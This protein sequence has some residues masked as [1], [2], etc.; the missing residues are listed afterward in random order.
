MLNEPKFYEIAFLI[1]NPEEEKAIVDL[2]N[3]YQGKIF[4]KAPLREIKLAYPIKKHTSAYFGCIQFELLPADIEKVS[5][6]VKLNSLILRHL[7]ITSPVM[8][9]IS[10]KRTEY[11]KQPLIARKQILTNEALEEKLEEILK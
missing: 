6:S 2:I 1:K 11:T 9:R 5:Q 7:T 3:Q 8:E 4:H 10:E